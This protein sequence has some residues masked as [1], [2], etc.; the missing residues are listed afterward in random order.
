VQCSTCKRNIAA[1]LRNHFCRV[2]AINITYSDCGSVALGK[3]H[4]TLM[5][6]I[7]LLAVASLAL[8]DI[9]TLSLNGTIFWKKKN[10]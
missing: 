8:Y 10:Y 9:F 2:K 7:I 3:Q 6:R 4:A 5:R 1:R